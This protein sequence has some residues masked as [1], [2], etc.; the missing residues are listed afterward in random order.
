[1]FLDIRILLFEK[2]IQIFFFNVPNRTG[3]YL[4]FVTSIVDILNRFV[5]NI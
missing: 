3:L 1:M 2:D 4:K 5:F